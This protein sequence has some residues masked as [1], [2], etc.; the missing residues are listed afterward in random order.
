MQ[1]PAVKA[2]SQTDTSRRSAGGEMGTHLYPR[3]EGI[4]IRDLWIILQFF[5]WTKCLTI[6][7]E[8]MVI[9]RR[10]HRIVADHRTITIM[11]FKQQSAAV[12]AGL[13]PHRPVSVDRPIHRPI[14]PAFFNP[15]NNPPSPLRRMLA[16]WHRVF[17][18]ARS[19]LP[20]RI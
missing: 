11:I 5:L 18:S 3:P 19:Y 17:P 4:V 1:Q 14:S 2:T 8:R 13:A 15:S 10:T 9:S 12:P 16:T 6:F 20:P 7:G